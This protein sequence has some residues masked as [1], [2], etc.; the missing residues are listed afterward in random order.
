MYSSSWFSHQNCSTQNYAAVVCFP[1]K[2]APQQNCTVLSCFSHQN[3]PTKLY[4]G[5]VVCFPAKTTYT[6]RSTKLLSKQNCIPMDVGKAELFSLF[7]QRVVSTNMFPPQHTHTSKCYRGIP[8][9]IGNSCGS[10]WGNLSVLREVKV[11]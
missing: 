11:A 6:K 1:A 3:F 7:P 9:N 2:T 10:S 5:G 4:I 8:P